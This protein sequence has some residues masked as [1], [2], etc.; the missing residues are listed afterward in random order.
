MGHTGPCI[1]ISTIAPLTNQCTDGWIASCLIAQH[2]TP[3]SSQPQ[4]YAKLGFEDHSS[5]KTQHSQQEAIWEKRHTDKLKMCCEVVNL[6]KKNSTVV[7]FIHYI[8]MLYVFH[9][10]HILNGS[11]LA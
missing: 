10:T 11:R 1:A 8:I 4:K 5:I 7:N 3:Y 6:T 2:V 9:Y